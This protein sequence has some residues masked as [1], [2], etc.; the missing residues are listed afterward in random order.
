MRETRSLLPPRLYDACKV[1][2][3]FESE[4]SQRRCLE[5]MAVGLVPAL[6]DRRDVIDPKYLYHG[7]L[8]HVQEAPA[9][10]AVQYEYLDVRRPIHEASKQASK[11]EIKKEA[12]RK[13]KAWPYLLRQLID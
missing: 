12:A 6:L 5:A 2:V 9:P 1:F 4:Q 7:N 13:K 10:S 8:L 3:T 11:L